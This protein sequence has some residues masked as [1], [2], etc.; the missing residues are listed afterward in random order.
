MHTKQSIEVKIQIYC[1]HFPLLLLLS[2]FDHFSLYSL[3]LNSDSS[4]NL[5]EFEFQPWKCLQPPL[6]MLL[7]LSPQLITSLLKILRHYLIP[8]LRFRFLLF[9][10]L[11]FSEWEGKYLVDLIL[12][13][14]H[15]Y[16]H[17]LNDLPFE[18]VGFAGEFEFK[19][20]D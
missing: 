17:Y 5:S 14:D 10:S 7:L 2:F 4:Q 20:L 16:F 18:L 6:K 19:G 1:F 12:E 3:N 9:S 11:W 13:V 8:I 15:P